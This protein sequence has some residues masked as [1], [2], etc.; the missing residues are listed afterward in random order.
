MRYRYLDSEYGC[1]HAA[2]RGRTQL[3]TNVDRLL[4]PDC[5]GKAWRKTY[6]KVFVGMNH[7]IRQCEWLQMDGQILSPATSSAMP[8]PTGMSDRTDAALLTKS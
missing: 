1:Q 2:Q 6:L 5:L 8:E 7:S 4:Y 3:E